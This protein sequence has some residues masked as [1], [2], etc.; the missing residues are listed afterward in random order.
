VEVSTSVKAK[1]KKVHSFIN[2]YKNN[3]NNNNL[4]LGPIVLCDLYFGDADEG[5]PP[6]YFFFLSI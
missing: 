1:T 6:L 3:N 4:W 5:F 2:D